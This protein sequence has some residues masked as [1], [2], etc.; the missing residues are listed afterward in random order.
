M[1]MQYVCTVQ[2]Y[3]GGNIVICDTMDELAKHYY[4]YYYYYRVLLYSLG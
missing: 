3:I 4:Y 2:Y 1:Q